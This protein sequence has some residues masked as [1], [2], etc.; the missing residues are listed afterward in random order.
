M[1]PAFIIFTMAILAFFFLVTGVYCAC[2]CACVSGFHTGEEM[3][4]FPPYIAI[5]NFFKLSCFSV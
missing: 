2:V 5:G 4:N 3:G 1:L